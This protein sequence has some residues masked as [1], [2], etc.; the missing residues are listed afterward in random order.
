[1]NNLRLDSLA[2]LQT[3][4]DTGLDAMKSL[5]PCR[6]RI[7]IQHPVQRLDAL[8]TQDMTVAANEHV[9]RLL[10]QHW[11]EPRLPVFRVP[12]NMGHPEPDSIKQKAVVRRV[13]T[14]YVLPI[15]ISGDDACRRD[16][17]KALDDLRISYV[18]RV[19]DHIA[20]LQHARDFRVKPAVGI[21]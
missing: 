1:M 4:A 6:T 20:I 19:E 17:L 8:N 16:F 10:I 12:P 5:P 14:Q 9:R 11:P 15:D 2:V 21:R 3:Q 13:A 18:S 7:Q